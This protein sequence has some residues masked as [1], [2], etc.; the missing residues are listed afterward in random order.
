MNKVYVIV[1]LV[2]LSNAKTMFDEENEKIQKPEHP[3]KNANWLSVLTFWYTIPIFRVGS[4]RDFDESD[5]TKPLDEHRSSMLGEKLANSWNKEIHRAKKH[6]DVPNL[7]KALYNICLKEIA[8]QGFFLFMMEIP[9][10]LCQPL[11]LGLLLRY[12][13]PKNEENKET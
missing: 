9:V 2:L 1:S 7:T 13:D 8:V 4:Q 3:R 6:H 10:R 12:F 5:L 11:F